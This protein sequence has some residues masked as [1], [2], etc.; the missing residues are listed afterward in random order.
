MTQHDDRRL[1]L[2]R[3]VLEAPSAEAAT[4]RDRHVDPWKRL[5]MQLGPL[6]GE[7]GFAAL[8]GRTTRQLAGRHNGLQPMSSAVPSVLLE[9]L[10]R[11]LGALQDD[12]AARVNAELL[13]TYSK[14]LSGLIGDALTN[15]ILDAAWGQTGNETGAQEPK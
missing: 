12:D 1:Q 5:S 10:G 8:L 3:Q 13:A 9:Q 2:I 7:S 15:R 11:D 4:A 6:I 14:L